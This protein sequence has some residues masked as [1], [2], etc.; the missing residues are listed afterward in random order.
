MFI[1]VRHVSI[2]RASGRACFSV[3]VCFSMTEIS[4][5]EKRK[6]ENELRMKLQEI[7][8]QKAESK[9][10]THPLILTWKNLVRASRLSFFV[11]L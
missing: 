7:M 3:T 6:A 1:F 10:S 11:Q 2:R 8:F 5:A 9:E 4:D